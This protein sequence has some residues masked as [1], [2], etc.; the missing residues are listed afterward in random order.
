ME[1]REGQHSDVATKFR[2][3]VTPWSARRDLTLGM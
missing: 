1:A 3:K 2:V